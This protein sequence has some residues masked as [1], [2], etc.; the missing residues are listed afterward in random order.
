MLSY[1]LKVNANKRADKSYGLW[2]KTPFPRLMLKSL[3][4]KFIMWLVQVWVA[5]L[6]FETTS[7]PVKESQNASATVEVGLL[8]PT[9]FQPAEIA[10]V[11][12]RKEEPVIVSVY[13]AGT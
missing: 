10:G 9:R 6:N 4:G 7:A 11:V 12:C 8:N 5:L 2:I 1:A 13:G 3:R